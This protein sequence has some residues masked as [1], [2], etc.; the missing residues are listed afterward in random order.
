MS[1][2]VA[3]RLVLLDDAEYYIELDAT[4]NPEDMAP[5]F[6]KRRCYVS[7][8]SPGGF[9]CVGRFALNERRHWIAEIDFVPEIDAEDLGN[10]DGT[11][12]LGVY[13]KRINAIVFLWLNR[14]R[15]HSR[16]ED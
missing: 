13:P 7:P 14:R 5:G 6:L 11:L 8:T 12:T 1:E 16:H 9:E 2:P 4:L 3:D 10:G 15:S